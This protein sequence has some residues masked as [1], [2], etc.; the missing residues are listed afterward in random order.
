MFC[1]L[2]FLFKTSVLNKKSFKIKYSFYLRINYHK[3]VTK[4]IK[5]DIMHEKTPQDYANE[6]LKMYRESTQILTK[7][8]TNAAASI[9][10]Q[11]TDS[12]FEDGT[13]G[14]QVNVTTLS[15]LYPVKGATVTVF[16]GEIKSPVV[17]ETDITDQSGQSG[18]FNLKTPPAAE[19]QQAENGGPLPYSNYNVSVKS[20]GYVEQIAINVPVFSGVV[21]VQSIDLIPL[22]AAGGHTS[23]QIIQEGNNYDL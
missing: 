4:H 19:S 20:D 17:I 6:L 13:G 10:E 1:I 16:T 14:L 15:R 9:V 22:A 7:N 18:I 21:S 8:V 5:G 12:I 23:P 11:D 2:T 3:I